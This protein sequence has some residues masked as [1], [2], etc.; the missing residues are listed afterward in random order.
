MVHRHAS[1]SW[2]RLRTP[3]FSHF[4]DALA[5]R[6]VERSATSWSFIADCIIDCVAKAL[7]T[8][9]IIEQV[10]TATQFSSRQKESRARSRLHW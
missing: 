9:A 10:D 5:G 6:V 7:Y 1:G 8:T 4:A 2:C 3:V